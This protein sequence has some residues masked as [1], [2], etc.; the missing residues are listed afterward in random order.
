MKPPQQLHIPVLFDTTMSILA[1]V[2]SEKY[3]DLTAGYGGHAREIISR[4]GG[5]QN[6]TLVDRD[7]NAIRE[8]SNQCGF[9]NA[10]FLHS[11]FLAAAEKL[12]TENQKF[13]MILMD[14]GVSSP[15]IDKAERGFSFQKEAALDMRMDES[16]E[17]S[18]YQV[19]NQTSEKKLSEY[20]FKFGDESPKMARKIAHSIVLNRPIKTTKELANVVIK[21]SPKRGKIHPATRT[22][23]AVRI[24][25]NDELRQIR[26]TLP[27]ALELLNS[28]GRIAVISFHSLEDVIVKN[29]FQE[30]SRAGY[31][32]TIKL[33]NKKPL[34]SDQNELV[35]NPRARSAKL[36]AAV[37]I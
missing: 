5:A 23:Q 25:V 26:E 34:T 3:L 14:L 17:L 32:A 7:E 1:P 9:A 31:E 15:Q 12:R 22:F 20:L 27:L 19:V 28:G 4:I 18:A 37:K 35:Y 11:D 24:I 2:A 16:Q 10:R 30:Q 13:D 36:R 21:V 6:A 29:Y 33:L 8:L